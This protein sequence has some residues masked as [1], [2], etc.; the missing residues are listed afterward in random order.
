[1]GIGLS[2]DGRYWSIGTPGFFSAFFDTVAVRLENGAQG[3]RFP[4]VMRDLYSGRLEPAAARNA[5]AE[6]DR[7]RA[8][9]AAHPPADV[10]WDAT[11]RTSRPPWGDAISADITDLSH[12]FVTDDGEDLL[13]VLGAALEE[14]ARRG[15]PLVVG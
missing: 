8:E 12:Y 14:S 2:V 5:L 3:S 4:V 11:D 15:Q 13:D 1:V 10:V 7:I 6:L 9:L